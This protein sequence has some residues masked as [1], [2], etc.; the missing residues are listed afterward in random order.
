MIFSKYQDSSQSENKQA[1][2]ISH[3][4][5]SNSLGVVSY[6]YQIPKIL[7]KGQPCKQAFFFFFLA[8]QQVIQDFSSLT[9]DQTH[10]SCTGSEVLI[11]GLP[12]KSP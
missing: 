2:S 7:A 4:V 9:R 6:M 8:L 1:L 3:T 5:C 10:T 12:R 11:T